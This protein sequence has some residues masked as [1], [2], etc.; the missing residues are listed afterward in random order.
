MSQVFNS[1][2]GQF[3]TKTWK[4]IRVGDI[5]IVK[6]G[7]YFPAD[8]MFLSAENSE[9]I[10]YIETMQLD[11]ETNLKIKKALDETK[12][13]KY[14]TIGKFAG[15][16]ALQHQTAQQAQLQ[17][18][19]VERKRHQKA[20]VFRPL[21]SSLCICINPVGLAT[22]EPPNSRLYQFTGKLELRPPLVQHARTVPLSPAA[23]LLR[24]CSLCNTAR[25]FGLVIYAGKPVC[26][27]LS[28]T[29]CEHAPHQA[30]DGF[31]HKVMLL[32]SLLGMYGGDKLRVKM[33]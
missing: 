30:S 7:E 5:I 33:G 23:V 22:C 25:I 19:S 27:I 16:H 28:S 17:H 6:K 10:C 9:G 26:W 18:C 13:L 1:S 31:L 32:C 29:L 11:G 4:D 3:E 20:C 21:T 14:H 2:M 8:L 12:D 24:G 15:D